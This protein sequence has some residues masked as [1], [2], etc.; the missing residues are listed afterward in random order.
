M[1]IIAYIPSD[2]TQS[3]DKLGNSSGPPEGAK[4]EKQEIMLFSQFLVQMCEKCFSRND[5][6]YKTQG[7]IVW[8]VIYF[9]KSHRSIK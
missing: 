2:V 9:R 6:L 1:D 5:G 4:W 8:F 7:L 3:G